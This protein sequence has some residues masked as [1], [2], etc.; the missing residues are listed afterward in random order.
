MVRIRICVSNNIYGIVFVLIGIDGSFIGKGNVSRVGNIENFS[1]S[2]VSI[3]SYHSLK[4]VGIYIS[5]DKVMKILNN[6]GLLWK[7]W[8]KIRVRIEEIYVSCR[9]KRRK[10]KD[11]L[12]IIDEAFL[13]EKGENCPNVISQ[14]S[15][16]IPQDSVSYV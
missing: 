2:I 8:R 12:T 13:K 10:I 5:V 4:K 1:S 14:T 15:E 3:L 9:R 11:T 6:K 16:Q 7:T